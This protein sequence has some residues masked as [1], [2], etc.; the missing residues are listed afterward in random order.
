MQPP[1][2]ASYLVLRGDAYHQINLEHKQELDHDN[3][4]IIFPP[5]LLMR[6]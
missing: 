2:F 1:L 3:K 5:S 6:Y 4:T